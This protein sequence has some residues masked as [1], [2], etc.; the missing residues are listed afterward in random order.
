M[1]KVKRILL[2]TDTF[3]LLAGGFLGPIYALYVQKIGGDILD[4]SISFALFMG[5]S[6][7][8][9]FLFS[10]W[11]D[12]K[13]HLEKFVVIGYFLGVVGY[14]MYLFVDSPAFLFVVQI[15]LGLSAALKD[16]S[17]DALFSES[18]KKHLALSWGEWEAMDYFALGAG[19]LLGGY[20]VVAYGFETLLYIML[21]ASICSFL[22]SLL[23]LKRRRKSK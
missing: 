2:L 7:V 12:K 1:D 19:A 3:Y 5:T 4:A 11:E 20:I 15:V 21:A 8:V 18:G 23:L 14:A 17:Y 22:I 16:P 10:L 6:G 13:K 9:V